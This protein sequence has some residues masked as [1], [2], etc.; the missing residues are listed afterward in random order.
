MTDR[1]SG[2]EEIQW[3]SKAYDAGMRAR[4]DGEDQFA[5]PR[6]SQCGL[7]YRRSWLAG[8]AD[9]DQAIMSEADGQEGGEN[10]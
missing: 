7:H 1:F 2:R 3:N 8:W 9:E 5:A 4:Q 6:I 10:A